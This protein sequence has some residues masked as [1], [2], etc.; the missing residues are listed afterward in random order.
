[1][2]L[3]T[4]LSAKY[5]GT[6]AYF[7]VRDRLPDIL[8][9]ALDTFHREWKTWSSSPESDQSTREDEAKA[10]IGQLSKLHYLMMTDKELENLQYDSQPDFMAW[11]KAMEA[12]KKNQGSALSWFSSRWLFV[13]CYLYRRIADIFLYHSKYFQ[14][15]D[16]FES[17]KKASLRDNLD[18]S[19]TI[20]RFLFKESATVK[21]WLELSLWGNRCDLSLSSTTPS[22]DNIV[23]HLKQLSSM[24]LVNDIKLVLDRIQQLKTEVGGNQIIDIVL[25]NA[26]FEFFTDLC[27][28]HCLTK[29]LPSLQKL[30]I[31]VKSYPWF[32]SDVMQKDV[33]WTLDVL[34]EDPELSSLATEWSQ[35]ITSGK[36]VVLDNNFWTLPYDYDRMQDIC[37]DLYSSLQQSSLIILKGDLNYRKLL[38][39]LA[40]PHDTPFETVL[41]NFKPNFLV[42]LR[43]NKADLICGLR[44]ESSLS[45]PDNYLVSGEYAVIQA[46]QCQ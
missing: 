4:P 31:H 19:R 10:I 37:P 11:M 28:M 13:E 5:K 14:F 12:E 36:W 6:F 2:S 40:W 44:N 20:G 3:P 34:K 35:W 39:D 25:D 7:T 30:R 41:R 17:Q 8:T 21:D 23:E 32:V 27:L 42:T 15:Y 22:F 16:P 45:L 9:R 46:F 29:T 33:P 38:G 18:S 43:T 26:G 1:M 24:I